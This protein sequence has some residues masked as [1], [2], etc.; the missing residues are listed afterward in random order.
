MASV[1]AVGCFSSRVFVFFST[2]CL[3]WQPNEAP[4][5][6]GPD[7]VSVSSVKHTSSTLSNWVFSLFQRSN[8]CTE[9]TPTWTRCVVWTV[10]YLVVRPV[11]LWV[12]KKGWRAANA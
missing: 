11:E 7:C 5:S 8:K 4:L 9:M 3:T 10:A 12:K 1:L 2:E 6:A